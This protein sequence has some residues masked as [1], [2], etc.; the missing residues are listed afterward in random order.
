M[1]RFIQSAWVAI[2]TL[3]F[4]AGAAFA[5]PQKDIDLKPKGQFA[6]LGNLEPANII[7]ALIRLLLVVAA[8]VFFFM[9]VLGGIQWILSGGDKQKTEAAR[10]QITAALVGLVVVFSAW[11]IAQLINALFG[12]NILDLNIRGISTSGQ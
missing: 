6:P 9:L 12:V 4:T 10:N 7:S 2:N 11:A 1:K 8:I 3:A 5:Q